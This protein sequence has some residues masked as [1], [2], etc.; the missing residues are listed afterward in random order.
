MLRQL[1]QARATPTPAKPRRRKAG[2]GQSGLEKRWFALWLSCGGERPVEQHRF[3]PS[4]KW[5]LDF[6]WV[7]DLVAVEI[8]GGRWSGGRHVRGDGFADDRAKMNA[9]LSLG[10]AV[11]ELCDRDI[12]YEAVERVAE[13]LFARRLSRVPAPST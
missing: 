10:W 12:G 8:H 4:R 13:T 2:D 1:R 7:D 6:A 5:R 3:H 11:F 9:A